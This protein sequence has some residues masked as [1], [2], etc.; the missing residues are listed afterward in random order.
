MARSVKH[1][2]MAF[3][4]EVARYLALDPVDVRRMIRMENLPVIGL[5]QETRCVYRV[6]LRDF[7]R[8][9]MEQTSNA[10]PL[11]ADYRCFMADFDATARAAG[12][13]CLP[14]ASAAAKPRRTSKKHPLP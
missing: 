6:P 1:S 7:H 11:L 10:T 5:R 9:L 13:P 8:W 2:P 14:P 4:A 3:V 12:G